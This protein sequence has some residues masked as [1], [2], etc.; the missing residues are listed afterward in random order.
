MT[1]EELLGKAR[2][3]GKELRGRHGDFDR[4]AGWLMAELADR[5]GGRAAAQAAED[6]HVIRDVTLAGPLIL[7]PRYT[8]P[9]PGAGVEGDDQP[10]G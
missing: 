4:F 7:D 8:P 2:Q 10:P 3:V 5:L 1:D 6:V 9:W